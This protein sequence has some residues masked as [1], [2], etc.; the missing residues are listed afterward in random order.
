MVG[1]CRY[2][3]RLGSGQLGMKKRI[4]HDFRSG[5]RLSPCSEPHEQTLLFLVPALPIP[6]PPEPEG[7][8]QRSSASKSYIRADRV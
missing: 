3:V 5:N 1:W 8:L 2:S 7:Y 4:D 6:L